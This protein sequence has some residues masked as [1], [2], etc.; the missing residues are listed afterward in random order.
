MPVAVP[1]VRMKPPIG[2]GGAEREHVAARG[3]ELMHGRAKRSCH[4][5][6]K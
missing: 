2:Q 4:R 3:N 1:G 5:A 6:H